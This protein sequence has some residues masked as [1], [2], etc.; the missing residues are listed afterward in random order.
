MAGKFKQGTQNITVSWT[1]LYSI[2]PW[3]YKI[4]LRPT[5]VKESV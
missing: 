1:V 5:V 4:T 3:T 2:N